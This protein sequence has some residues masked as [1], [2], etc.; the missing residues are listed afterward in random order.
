MI[1]KAQI[2][3]RSKVVF[4]ELDLGTNHPFVNWILGVSSGTLI[5]THSPS[6]DPTCCTQQEW[7]GHQHMGGV[8]GQYKFPLNIFNQFIETFQ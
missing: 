7:D 4:L 5:L 8:E 2:L 3:R 1:L 6:H